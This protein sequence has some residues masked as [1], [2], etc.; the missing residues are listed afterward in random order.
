[1][2][3]AALRAGLRVAALK[4]DTQG[5][6]LAIL[7]GAKKCLS[8]TL[9]AVELEVEF[10]ELYADQPLFA[11]VDTLMRK[12]GF[13]LL[14]L[15]NLVCHKW[16]QST[17]LGGFKGQLLAADAL[18]LRTPGALKEVIGLAE[19]PLAVLSHYWAICAVYGYLDMAYESTVAISEESLCAL[20]VMQEVEN[21]AQSNRKKRGILNL[22]GRGRF[23]SWLRKLA[24]EVEPS[25]HTRWINPL[26]NA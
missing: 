13:M 22:R 26:G 24:D 11:D 16:R 8:E 1:L 6:E 21:W 14:D 9:L 3:D 12:S 5:T 20:S 4:A 19:E 15:G 17:G 2:D 23:A 18:Y 7:R 25:H 10:T